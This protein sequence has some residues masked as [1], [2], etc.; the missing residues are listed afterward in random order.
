MDSEQAHGLEGELERQSAWM[1]RLA[2]RLVTGVAGAEDALSQA[3]LAAL[4]RERAGER[5]GPGWLMRATLNLARREQRDEAVRRSHEQRAARGE[6]QPPAD[7]LAA[8]LEAQ[9]ALADELRALPE[10]YRSALVRHFFD[11]WSAAR[12]ARE[13]GCPATTVRTRLERGL[14]LLRERLDRRSGGRREWLSALAPLALPVV[15]R[16]LELPTASVANLVQGV[17]LMNLGLKLAAG[18][19]LVTALGVSWLWSER[20]PQAARPQAAAAEPQLAANVPASLDAAGSRDDAQLRASTPSAEPTQRPVQDPTPATVT[21]TSIEARVLDGSL[22]A[23]AK[24]RVSTSDD[25]QTHTDGDGRFELVLSSETAGTSGVLRIEAAGYAHKFLDFTPQAGVRKHLGDIVLERG[26]TLAGR[27]ELIDGQ[28]LSGARVFVTAPSVWEDD[29]EAA[30]RSGPWAA[31]PAPSTTSAAD[32]SFQLEGVT[33]GGARVWAEAPGMRY[34]LSSALVL[35]AEELR[36]GVVIVVEPL[37]RE[38]E[39]AGVVLDPDG[40]ALEGAALRA[41]SAA[42]GNSHSMSVALDPGGRFRFRVRR[43][44]R[45]ELL[46]SDPLNRWPDARASGVA[47]G[48]HDVVLRFEL[49]R[50]VSVRAVGPDGHPVERVALRALD[51]SGASVLER[52]DAA[53]SVDGRN[54]VRV[55]NRPFL[56][57]CAVPGFALD[58][59]GPFAPTSA[60]RELEFK[61]TP[62]PGLSGR[63]LASDR[64]LS[65][66]RVTLWRL[67]RPDEGIEVGG[68]PALLAPTAVDSTISEQDGSYFLRLLED[69]AYVVRADASGY[70]PGELGPLELRLGQGLAKLDLVLGAGGAIEGRVLVA[71]GRSDEGVIVV[72][73]RGDG[74]VRTQRTGAGGRFRFDGLMVGPWSVSRG[75][76]DVDGDPFNNWAIGSARTPTKLDFNCTVLEGEATFVQLD[77]RDDETARV[78]GRLTINGEPAARWLLTAWPGDKSSYV[79]ELP[80]TTLDEH[81]EFQLSLDEPGAVRFTFARAEEGQSAAHISA[82]TEL[83]RGANDWSGDVPTLRVSGRSARPSS[84]T[85]ALFATIHSDALEAFI[86]IRTDAEGR[87][88]LPLAL[89]GRAKFSG[90]HLE[91]GRWSDTQT[92]HEIVLVRGEERFVELP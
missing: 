31:E 14:E 34:G 1:R 6:A 59:Q 60:P 32:G 53:S 86:P 65:G 26:A 58:R 40:L 73:N 41:I 25:D 39:I 48:D 21:R 89:E 55:P 90:A 50:F 47:P 44:A 64:A 70:A 71:E 51:E 3:R 46:S 66:A 76:T 78:R 83:R 17:L 80:S 9:R 22:R 7:E 68:Y 24:A 92:L 2:R 49:P 63:V 27:V 85:Y 13:A 91:G 5:V 75:R 23:L 88:E 15:P 11:G 43:D 19:A 87:F 36:D 82:R 69:G 4:R 10:P 61:L 52:A 29:S 30:K 81:G 28:P 79:G 74:H 35:R 18:A 72:A 77:L 12:I 20:P 37:R 67:G 16:W 38:D 42:G 54:R 62:Q 45:H 56:V 84:D 33:P 8:R 57:E